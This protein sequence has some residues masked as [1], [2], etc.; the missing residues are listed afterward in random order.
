MTYKVVT[1]N[2]HNEVWAIGFH[3]KEKAQNLI[4]TGYF[5]RYMYEQDKNKTLIIKE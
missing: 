5:H 2:N 4:D 3:S 1:E